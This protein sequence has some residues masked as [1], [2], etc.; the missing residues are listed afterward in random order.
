LL[1]SSESLIK[2]LVLVRWLAVGWSQTL[3]PVF[4]K[5]DNPSAELGRPDLALLISK[6]LPS[7]KRERL[8]VKKGSTFKSYIYK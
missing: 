7:L 4:I 3:Y 2:R 8:L 5:G 1:G 6:G